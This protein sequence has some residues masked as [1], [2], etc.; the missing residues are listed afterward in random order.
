M[1]R[2]GETIWNKELKYQGHTDI[3]LSEEGLKQAEAVAARFLDEK[4]EAVY[5]SDLSR[6]FITAKAIADKHHL[7]VC[8]VPS[9][10]EIKFG[11]WEGLT[12]RAI[13]DRWPEEMSRLYTHASEVVVPGGES[14]SQLKERASDAID[15]LVQKHSDETFVVVAHGGTIRAILCAI[16]G[17]P[18]DNVWNFR[19]DNTAVNII[20]YYEGRAIVGLIN[21]SHHLQAKV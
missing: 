4:I 16:L 7:P 11:D 14:F 13:N 12:Y 15:Q 10:R 8:K 9:L 17:V 2:H 5:S 18:L 3:E 20:E 6:A 21:D 1:I 19:Q